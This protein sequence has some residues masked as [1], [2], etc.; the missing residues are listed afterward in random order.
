[1]CL[2]NAVTTQTVSQRLERADLSP[3][4]FQ[5]RP[6]AD[7]LPLRCFPPISVSVTTRGHFLLP[8]SCFVVPSWVTSSFSALS[9]LQIHETH[10]L[11]PFSF[12]RR[13]HPSLHFQNTRW[14][15]PLAPQRHKERPWGVGSAT[16]FGLSVHSRKRSRAAGS[17]RGKVLQN[18]WWQARIQSRRSE[19]EGLEVRAD[20]R[21]L[22][23]WFAS[24]LCSWESLF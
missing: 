5:S 6:Q 7:V 24:V 14:L 15:Q 13:L 16:L 10:V 8:C 22:G 9:F 17:G 19:R 3:G 21:S 23:L 2:Y 4:G 11:N 1:M 18:S 20:S 12:Q